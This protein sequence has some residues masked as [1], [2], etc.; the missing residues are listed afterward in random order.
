MLNT[1]E[2]RKKSKKTI[3]LP[4]G[5]DVAFTNHTSASYSSA[6]YKT[7]IVNVEKTVHSWKQS[8]FSYEWLNK[9]GTFKEIEN[10]TQ[11]DQERRRQILDNIKNGQALETPILGMGILDNVEIGVGRAVFLT[12]A[13]MGA[14]EIP[15]HVPVSQAD[16]FDKFKQP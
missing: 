6:K 4:D 12:L 15:V 7:I 8:L 5:K 11:K 10:L 14:T 13:I 1:T 9:D 16:F 2:T 3:T